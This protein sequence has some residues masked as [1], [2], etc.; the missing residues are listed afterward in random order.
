M[1][2]IYHN[3]IFILLFSVISNAQQL[4]INNITKADGLPSNTIYTMLEDPKGNIWLATDRGLFKYNGK[5][6]INYTHPKQKGNAFFSLKLDPKGRVW[7]NNISGQH[8]YVENNTL[9]LFKNLSHILKGNLGVFDFFDDELFVINKTNRKIT[10]IN[11]TTKQETNTDL[12]VYGSTLGLQK[13]DKLYYLN[14][15]LQVASITN[16]FKINQIESKQLATRNKTIV[17]HTKF[18]NISPDEIWILTAPTHR[19]SSKIYSLK[20]G[21]ITTLQLPKSLKNTRI[22]DVINHNG[23]I[24]FSTDTGT[25]ITKLVNNHISITNT[26]LSDYFTTKTIIDSNNNIW[27]STLSS[28]VFIIPNTNLFTIK[29]NIN[30]TAFKKINDSTCFIGTKSG[31]IYQYQA[32]QHTLKKHAASQNSSILGLEYQNSTST[33]FI[34]S[35]N[36]VLRYNLKSGTSKILVN[37]AL[38]IKSLALLNNKLIASTSSSTQVIDIHK[39]NTERSYIERER[40]FKSIYS[41]LTNAIYINNSNG[42]NVYDASYNYVT[43]LTYN[44]TAIYS[45]KLTQTSDSTIWTA[46]YK[47]PVIGFKNNKLHTVI[48]KKKGLATHQVYHLMASDSLLWIATTKGLQ[49]YNTNS[50]QLKTLTKQD[51]L[52]TYDINNIEVL[53]NT[54]LLSSNGNLYSFDQTKVF[55][56]RQPPQPIINTVIINNKPVTKTNYYKLKQDNSNIQFKFNAPGYQAHK[57]IEFQYKLEGLDRKWVTIDA[58][59][60]LIQFKTL[61]AGNF[62]FILRAKNKNDVKYVYTVPIKIK[63]TALFYKTWWFWLIGSSILIGIIIVY[64][65][66]KTK[67][68]KAQQKANLEKIQLSNDLVLSQLEALRSQMNP[69]FIFNALNSIQDYIILNEQKLAREFLVSFSKLIRLYLEHSQKHEVVLNQELE[70]LNLYLKLEKHRFDDNF[71]YHITIDEKINT[72][73]IKVPS[74]LIQPYVENAIKHGLLHKKD[75]KLLTITFKLTANDKTMQCVITDNGIG[76]EA[77]QQINVKRVTHN[78][79]ALSANQKR[80]DLLNQTKNNLIALQILDLKTDNNTAAGT[81]VILNIGI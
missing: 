18:Y 40:G 33:L 58:N 30:V 73:D 75:N 13:K 67:Q 36:N 27:I 35:N 3:Y 79:F 14:G 10:R 9:V 39:K 53:D 20:N 21:K 68:L 38:G 1:K 24:Y 45:S 7:C 16:T 26:I 25:Y 54:V 29:N 81:K 50:K 6:Y 12:Y 51:G 60:N 76:R 37:F 17:A 56:K 71:E 28:G 15:N 2:F 62:N 41:P 66:R 4:V 44:N 65:Q 55:K 70:A 57:F 5:D 46:H 78:S 49:L 48:D 61:P 69:H 31:A 52:I 19:K 22:E 23:T 11:L 32:N 47:N 42:I 80:I 74:L 59:S 77:S 34:G 63:V 8:F 64:Q 43:S 72:T